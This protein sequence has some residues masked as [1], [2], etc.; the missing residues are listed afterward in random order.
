MNTPDTK[1]TPE[2]Y[3]PKISGQYENLSSGIDC[4]LVLAAI[5]FLGLLTCVLVGAFAAICWSFSLTL[6][7]VEMDGEHMI[8]WPN[9][10]AVALVVALL[11]ATI[12]LLRRAN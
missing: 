2:Y 3:N 10:V 1:S 6:R 8:H 9:L 4:M 11:H 7:L 5:C 12:K